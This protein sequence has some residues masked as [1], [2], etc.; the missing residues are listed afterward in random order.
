MLTKRFFKTKNELDVTFELRRPEA[1]HID[2]A[3]ES[4]DWELIP[5]RRHPGGRFRL[6]LR[7]PR[8]GDV[9]FRYLVDGHSWQNDEAADAYW[10]NGMGS[11]NSVAFT[12]V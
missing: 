12:G 10:S 4:H 1:R 2:L 11:D 3:I 6:K 5:M 7:L 8:G 9:Q